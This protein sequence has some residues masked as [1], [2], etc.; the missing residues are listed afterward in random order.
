MPGADAGPPVPAI[1][2][3]PPVVMSA[4]VTGHQLTAEVHVPIG[5][6]TAIQEAIARMGKAQGGGG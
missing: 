3:A 5:A 6:I 2:N 4:G 1:V